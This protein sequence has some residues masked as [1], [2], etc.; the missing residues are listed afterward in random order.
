L[1]LW[2]ILAAADD[3]SPVDAVEAVASELGKALGAEAVSFLIADNN[4]RALVRLAHV[5]SPH[6]ANGVRRD[7]AESA[8]TIPLDGG[9]A[10]QALRT[11][12]VQVVVP[13]SPDGTVDR[14]RVLAPVTERGDVMGL[15]DMTLAVEPSAETLA[16]VA[17]VGHL[18]S[19]VVTA[20][21]RHTDLFE[22]GQRS[23][24]FT[25][26]AEIQQ[27]LLPLSRTCEAASFTLAGWLEPAASIGGD[28]FDY[29]LA[30]DV[31][32]LSLTDAMGHGV[33]SALT[34]TV[35][36]ASLRGSRRVGA[37]LVEAVQEANT[38][39]CQHAARVGG[40]DFATGVIGRV[41]LRTGMLELVNAGHAAPFLIRSGTVSEL[42][43]SPHLPLG[44]FD[45]TAYASTQVALVRGDRIVLVTDGMLERHG[46]LVDLPSILEETQPL[47]PREAVRH[48]ADEALEAAGHQ[49]ADDATILCLDW[50]GDHDDPRRSAVAGADPLRASDPL[51]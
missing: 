30:R 7:E 38:Q 50:H 42:S 32:H 10:E 37:T 11:Q 19:Y 18:L 17:R 44:M 23:R 14:W 6:S 51:D 1:D 46:S 15:L 43:L 29:S 16:T 9:P 40:D 24:P 25:L 49:L 21:R 28:T 26:S 8:T 22:W 45:D 47:H 41:D 12:S 39:L 2:R 3:A 27:R 20:N 35:G 5:A 31:L 33:G 48:M 13:G 34:A 36:I 4:G